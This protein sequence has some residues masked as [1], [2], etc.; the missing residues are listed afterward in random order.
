MLHFIHRHSLPSLGNSLH[1][2]GVHQSLD[3]F[4]VEPDLLLQLTTLLLLSRSSSH[5]TRHLHAGLTHILLTVGVVLDLLRISLH[6]LKILLVLLE[7]WNG[8]RMSMK[9]IS[10]PLNHVGLYLHI[11]LNHFIHLLHAL[12]HLLSFK[13]SFGLAAKVNANCNRSDTHDKSCLLQEFALLF[14]SV[15]LLRALF[16]LLFDHFLT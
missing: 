15:S 12:L 8:L 6:I 1:L 4:F 13:F 7:S 9:R 2:P 16:H 10:L 5:H 11:W 14:A 3:L